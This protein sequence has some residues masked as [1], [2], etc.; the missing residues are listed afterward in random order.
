M[1]P[2]GLVCAAAA[3]STTSSRTRRRPSVA[4]LGDTRADLDGLHERLVALLPL[5]DIGDRA[6]EDSRA[7][8]RAAAGSSS[9]LAAPPRRPRSRGGSH[10]RGDVRGGRPEGAR[11]P[12]H[13]QKPGR[14]LALLESADRISEDVPS[15]TRRETAEVFQQRPW[16]SPASPCCTRLEPS[17]S[18]ISSR[19]HSPRPRSKHPV[20]PPA[21]PCSP[22]SPSGHACRSSA[23]T[24][25]RRRANTSVTSSVHRFLASSSRPGRPECTLARRRL[26][27]GLRRTPH[28]RRP[29][30]SRCHRPYPDASGTALRLL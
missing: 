30:G 15:R 22:T 16:R 28:S 14:A 10:E 9:R 24:R 12:N 5:L 8:H 11:Q 18:G 3:A 7:S 13:E 2:R 27:R 19:S 25:S 21:A 26:L 20:A 23:P 29:K 17:I 1:I 6:R 4:P